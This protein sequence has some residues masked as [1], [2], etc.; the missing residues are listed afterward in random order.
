M[1]KIVLPEKVRKIM[2]KFGAAGA[3]I[4][5]VGGAVRDLLMGREVKDWDFATDLTPEEMFE[6]F[7]KNAFYNNVYGT[8]SIVGKNKEIFEVT[9]FRT[10]KEYSDNRHP[11]KVSWGKS[12]EEDLERRDFTINAMAIQLP[13]NSYELRV[14]DLY[15]G[16]EDLKKKLI[17]AVGDP[18]E[19]FGE[20]ALRMMR[21]IRIASQIGFAIE[22]KTFGSIVKNAKLFLLLIVLVV[23]ILWFPVIKKIS[24]R[25][26]FWGL[27][28]SLLIS[29]P[30][31]GDTLRGRSG[32][33]FSYISIFTDPTISTTVDYHR[34]QD[35]PYGDETTIGS[36]PNFVS[37]FHHNKLSLVFDKFLRNYV[38]SFSV[39]FHLLSGD[40]NLRQGFGQKGNF[41][42][43]DAVFF[44]LGLASIFL[45]PKLRRIILFFLLWLILAPI[46]FALTRDSISPHSTRL[47]LML[48]PI[49]FF[50]VLGLSNLRRLLP[51]KLFWLPLALMY[52][53][54]IISFNHFYYYHYP[55]LSA[56]SWHFGLKK[57]ILE[58]T[59][60]ASNYDRLYYSNQG[61]SLLPF[62]YFYTQYLPQNGSCHP[63]SGSPYFSNPYFS[64][65]L[66]EAKYYFGSLD[67]GNLL[68]KEPTLDRSLY[69]VSQ[70]EFDNLQQMLSQ[71]SKYQQSIIGIKVIAIPPKI[72]PDQESY[73]YFTFQK[74]PI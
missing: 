21:A 64:G 30:L 10:E 67:W 25:H 50:I 22:E 55:A 11:D 26:L 48:P 68:A 60:I 73:Y 66:V 8:F 15:G 20:D 61:E 37:K 9:T 45:Y 72:Y 46:P 42:Y 44:L 16:Q 57:V 43:L 71:H 69:V 27:L 38:S 13:V 24:R 54:E 23:I 7:P 40:S 14:I 12:L 28:L 1:D 58:T 65:R 36:Q 4:Y 18:D 47:I 3:E 49:F 51:S 19:R 5:V 62:F 59:G 41:Y 32:Y 35:L 33:R 31:I 34:Y 29:L 6:I 53:L 52:F 56:R 63:V 17:K 39:D 74:K 70:Q 2:E